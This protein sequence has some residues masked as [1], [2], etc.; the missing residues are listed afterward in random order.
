MSADPFSSSKLSIAKDTESRDNEPQFYQE[1]EQ[2]DSDMNDQL[3]DNVNDISVNDQSHSSERK[4]GLR[5]TV[6]NN[7]QMNPYKNGDGRFLLAK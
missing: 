7:Y 3:I 5:F 1:E 2:S 4:S 6:Q